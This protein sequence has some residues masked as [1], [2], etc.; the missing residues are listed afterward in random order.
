M[1]IANELSA[2]VIGDIL[3]QGMSLSGV[4]LSERVETE[5]VLALGK[6]KN[7]LSTKK[8]ETEKLEAVKKIVNEYKR[9]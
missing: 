1:D 8:S 5:A 9:E 7:E 6:I 3:A 4:D 2:K